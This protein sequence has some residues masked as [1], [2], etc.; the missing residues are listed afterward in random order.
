MSNDNQDTVNFVI[1]PFTK[2]NFNVQKWKYIKDKIYHLNSTNEEES[3]P[4]C[5]EF[6]QLLIE[7][8]AYPDY[9]QYFGE[10]SIKQFFFQEFFGHNAKNLIAT[11]TFQN[12][13]LLNISNECLQYMITFWVK[14]FKED[15]PHLVEMAKIILDPT[16]YYY[17]CNDQ[18]FFSPSVVVRILC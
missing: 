4:Y 15:N 17:K 11:R 6:L 2:E 12:G 13:N 1:G 5:K 10:P 18:E 8:N 14:A 16:K 3:L 7:L 9:N